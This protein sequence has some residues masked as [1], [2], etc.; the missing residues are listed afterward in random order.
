MY[1][2][3]IIENLIKISFTL[4]FLILGLSIIGAT[5]A[6]TLSIIV[7]AILAFYFLETKIL[8]IFKDKINSSFFNKEL[9]FYSIPLLFSNLIL[10]II[11]WT[12]TLMLGYFLPES[13]VG[14]Y[15]TALPTAYLMNMIPYALYILFLPILTELY[16]KDKNNE[17]KIVYKTVTKWVFL[18]NLILLSM[19]YL[20]SKPIITILFGQN[21][22]GAAT[23]LIILGTGYFI[24][25]FPISSQ[26]FLLIV[27]KTKLILF[28]TLFITILNILLNFYLIPIYGF[29]GA[30]IA[31]SSVFIFRGI[32]LGIES[33]LIEKLIPLKLNF[34]K[35]L[36]SI[37]IASMLVKY[38]SRFYP[39]NIFTLAINGVLLLGF[40]S[41]LLLITKSFEKEDI[42]IIKTI[43]Q[44]TGV[45]FTKINNFLSKFT[46]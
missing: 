22:V 21:Y 11:L 7:G 18:M 6:Y 5:I 4:I 33:Y 45:D 39:I 19:F 15:N 31:T 30:A 36:F 25:Y 43:Q 40:Y 17:F 42:M 35:I 16:S 44:K 8:S 37:L 32:L 20:F 12:D 3:C 9:L 24:G 38:I 27:K 34:I 14:I 1:I 41:L 23:S 13:E 2:R 10:S 26:Y 28:N 29:L 46:K